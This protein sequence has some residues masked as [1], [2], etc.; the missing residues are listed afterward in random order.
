M[1]Y[2]YCGYTTYCTYCQYVRTPAPPWPPIVEPEPRAVSYAE[3]HR[4]TRGE[5]GRY[6]HEADG[7]S[8]YADAHNQTRGKTGRYVDRP[9]RH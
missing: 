2:E 5:S 6:V 7:L 1:D 8:T 9:G 3:A 4:S